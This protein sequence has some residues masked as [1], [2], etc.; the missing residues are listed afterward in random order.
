MF[1]H[2][3]DVT[4]FVGPVLMRVGRCGHAALLIEQ[5]PGAYA[6]GWQRAAIQGRTP[7]DGRE[8]PPRAYAPGGQGAACRRSRAELMSI[9]LPVPTIDQN[10]RPRSGGEQLGVDEQSAVVPAR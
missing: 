3:I 7:L 2:Q 10:L 9:V 1:S 5:P 4:P 8:Q 6:P